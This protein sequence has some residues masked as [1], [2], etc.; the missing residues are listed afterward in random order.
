MITLSHTT[1]KIYDALPIICVGKGYKHL[2]GVICNNKELDKAS[3]MPT[4]LDAT[5]WLIVMNVKIDMVDPNAPPDATTGACSV[6]KLVTIK[7]YV[8]DDNL[9]KQSILE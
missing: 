3:Y 4:Y 2:D 5:Q 1:L 9:Q 8:F 7:T 6:F